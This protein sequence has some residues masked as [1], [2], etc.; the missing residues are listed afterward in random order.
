M[1]TVTP[2]NGLGQNEPN[3]DKDKDKA[4]APPAKMVSCCAL[5]RYAKPMDMG[6]AILGMLMG[7][8]AGATQPLLMVLFGDVT[9]ATTASTNL[10]ETLVPSIILMVYVAIGA[11]FTFW[12]AFWALPHAAAGIASRLRQEYFRAV[13]RQDLAYFDA[14]QA[15]EVAIAINEK[16]HDVEKA[17]SLKM[18]EL[19]QSVAQLVLGLVF[20]FY[21]SW[22]LTLVVIAM[23]PL[24]VVATYCMIKSGL[25]LEQMLGKKA[26]DDA[27]N[28]AAEAIGSMRTVASFGGEISMAKRYSS[29]LGKAQSA[30]I[31]AG[32]KMAM[33]SSVM[34]FVFFGI[35]GVGFWYGGVL[36]ADARTK[37]LT[38]HPVP[39]GF[40][41]SSYS[42]NKTDMSNPWQLH[43]MIAEEGKFCQFPDDDTYAKC[44]CDIKFSEIDDLPVPLKDPNCGCGWRSA[45]FVE[46]VSLNTCPSVGSVITAFWCILIGGFSLG[47]VGP[48]IEAI[49][50]GRQSAHRLYEVIDRKPTIDTGKG[51][52]ESVPGA[53]IKKCKG[54]IEFKNV[55][56]AYTNA[57][58][59]EQLRPVFKNL[60]L[61]IQSGETV[62]FVGESGS[63]KSTIGKLVSRFY[64]PSQGQVL[65]DGVDVTA[66][67]VNDLRANIGIVSQEP[68]LFDTT[69]RENIAFGRPDYA[70]VTDAE[71]HS[72]AKA[73]NAHDFI[74]S[75]QF[76][77]KYNT[78]VGA[79]GGKLS[80]GQK[81]RIAIARAM[82]RNPPILILDEATSAL[83]TKSEA[84]VQ[85]ALDDLVSSGQQERTTIVIAHRLS[86]VRSADRIVVLGEGEDGMGGG[87]TIVEQGTHD[88]L[89]AKEGVYHALVGA[90]G[91]AQGNEEGLSNNTESKI[92]AEGVSAGE[93]SSQSVTSGD[94]LQSDNSESN[95]PGKSEG[96]EDEEDKKKEE[97]YKVPSSRVWSYAKD[98]KFIVAMGLISSAC[99][100]CIFPCLGLFFAEMLGAYAL[101]DDSEM[102]SE[103]MLWMFVQIGL[104]VGAYIFNAGQVGFFSH[105]G[106]KITTGIRRDL[107]KSILRQDITFFDD[108]KN[109]VGALMT[110]L[111]DDAATVQNV[112][113]QQLGSLLN[114]LVCTIFGLALALSVSWRLTL[115]LLGAIPPLAIAQ[116][117]QQQMVMS[118]EKSVGNAMEESVQVVTESV[119]QA[120]EI[121]AFGLQKVVH[122]FYLKLLESPLAAK[123]KTAFGSGFAM[124]I[125]QFLTFGF[126]AGAFYYGGWLVENK[127]IDF[128]GFMK[129]LFVLA[130]MASGA[131]QAATYAGNQAR[132]TAATSKIFQLIDRKPPIDTK[133][134]DDDLVNERAFDTK[135][136]VPDTEF[137]GKVELQGV[138][139]AYP[140]RSDADV[141]TGLSLTVEPGKTVALVGTSGSGKSTVIQ[142]LE[143][144]YDPE[145][146]DKRKSISGI[147]VVVDTVV[148]DVAQ[149]V[150]ATDVPSGGRILIDGRDIRQLDVKWLRSQV[151]LV[152]QEPKLFH[153]SI[154]ENIA[155][156]KPGGNA[157]KEEVENAARAANAYDFIMGFEKGFDSDVGPG[158]SK[159][160][161][162]QKQRVAIARAI[163]KNPKILLLDEATSALDNES[164]KI[165]QASL[166]ALLA[167]KNSQRTTIVIAHRLSTIRNADCI[168]VLDRDWSSE[169][170]STG[171][172]VAEK[173]THEELM[174]K[175]GK[176]M[177]LRKA[178]D[179]ASP[180]A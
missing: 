105:S 140:T 57:D 68:L 170:A 12:I 153:G 115:A 96:D 114:T 70:S 27:G 146:L 18:A 148:N 165:V 33:S 66:L 125:V 19:F 87:T 34:W 32:W 42:K 116:A 120:K 109:S 133:P 142:L 50:K 11:A 14:R 80:G 119:S 94:K 179:G 85:K 167:D 132:A 35:Q 180:E 162:G 118:G 154:F 113:G 10:M 130:F 25:G 6:F 75:S 169:N 15:G 106:E 97:A 99:N 69:I 131:G 155:M 171:S 61:K 90:Q 31:S 8:C 144:F 111:G 136:T 134:W 5:F 78:Q 52:S 86:T 91:E 164:E 9:D 45:D 156:G 128:E 21:Y 7:A 107:F 64:D 92:P 172:I 178:F 56:Y 22:E 166:D 160:S 157:S 110:L 62:A 30:A 174:A 38:D 24:L 93:A 41:L 65:V 26:Y 123:R 49:S 76:P 82:L 152:G 29:Y 108:P 127:F 161:G 149:D 168:Y 63:G 84:I 60:S 46:G 74:N 83:D 17:L 53:P 13:L 47:Q 95:T 20:A 43:H 104:G 4:D 176:Y 79:R 48:A 59:G 37:A 177:M 159:L 145:R 175:G 77:K 147:D 143:R 72:A 51:D 36:V 102:R 44:M 121:Q 89:M 88:E 73:A 100:G 55:T 173:G 2:E 28:M 117:L 98:S 67:N 103:L 138:H 124:G 112:T 71:I 150:S 1:A 23:L 40:S 39:D 16:V 141:F 135:R 126:Y 151:G 54:E 139:F 137:N 81:Q 122:G 3:A 129:A 158:G 101:Y 163:I 58:T